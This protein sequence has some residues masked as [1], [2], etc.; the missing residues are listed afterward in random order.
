ML[1]RSLKT[2]QAVPARVVDNFLDNTADVAV[3]FSKVEGTQPRGSFV[4]VGMRFELEQAKVIIGSN[5]QCSGDVRWHET[6][7]VL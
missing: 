7:S 3:P 1:F 6:A 2:Q 5:R 4:Q